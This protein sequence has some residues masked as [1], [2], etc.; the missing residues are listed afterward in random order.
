MMMNKELCASWD[1]PAKTIVLH[2][3]EPSKLQTLALDFANK[4][5]AF[6][7]LNETI[8]DSRMMTNQ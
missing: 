2:Q 3:V 8:L 7:E 1:Q 4:I 5:E 6:V